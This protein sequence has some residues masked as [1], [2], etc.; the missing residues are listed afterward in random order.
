MP[1]S[2]DA[3]DRVKARQ[4]A[5]RN[6]GLC[7]CGK[8]PRSGIS[9]RTKKPYKTCQRCFQRAS[10]HNEQ[11]REEKKDAAGAIDHGVPF[12]ITTTGLHYQVLSSG[13]VGVVVPSPCP[14]PIILEFRDG[15]RDAFHLREL[16]PT[17]LS[18]SRSKDSTYKK[19]RNGKMGRPRGVETITI[20]KMLAV[21]GYLKR[22]SVSLKR[23]VIEKEMGF[24]CTRILMQLPS[25]PDDKINLE[26]LGIVLRIPVRRDKWV[27]WELTP[28][29][30][31][32]GEEI[33]HSLK[34][35]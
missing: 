15:S 28:L 16:E 17:A 29:G 11:E 21:H 24:D 20:T 1:K 30:R 34:R 8:T 25:D 9:A 32:K 6:Q 13:E 14:D 26:T 27:A 5:L 10:T 12:P 31:E 22:Q 4:Q 7:A 3:G 23:S 19:N 2:I 33:I 18:V 35:R